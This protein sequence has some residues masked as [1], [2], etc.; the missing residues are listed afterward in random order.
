MKQRIGLAI[1]LLGTILIGV[2]LFRMKQQPKT[3]NNPAGS[4]M[5]GDVP[6]VP[7]ASAPKPQQS[8]ATANE[9][10]QE[11]LPP[12]KKLHMPSPANEAAVPP[13]LTA[14]QPQPEQAPQTVK[15][16]SQKSVVKQQPLVDA[17]EP[18]G[19][20]NNEA[21][22]IPVP[23]QTTTEA[24]ADNNQVQPSG[25][26]S[27]QEQL[28]AQYQ[29]VK[30]GANTSGYSVVAE[31]TLLAVQKGGILAVPYSDSTDFKTKYQ[32]GQIHTPSAFSHE[33][34]S[35]MRKFGKPQE[36]HLFAKG[37]KVYPTKID[38]NLNNDSVTL[39]IVACNP[40]VETGSQACNKAE[41]VFQFPKGALARTAAGAVEDVIG[42]VFAISNGDS[43]AD[44][45]GSP[46]G[47]QPDQALQR[48]DNPA[49]APA[50]I[51]MGMTPEEVEAIMGPPDKKVNIGAK[52]IYVYKDIRVL[53]MNG[54]VSDVQ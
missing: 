48:T 11:T 19:S 18:A 30:I 5:N 44:Q 12:E 25:A 35:L 42:Q 53:F 24:S 37:D 3:D 51:T 27:L 33:G 36:T 47:H 17:T 6:T 9:E 54:R 16:Q 32:N 41:V 2:A 39:G 29:M 23:A 50:T 43:N 14:A 45:E 26:V 10:R 15:E 13:D 1:L 8:A 21:A 49:S 38:V 20:A 31:G 40:S 4:A 7:V 34:N 28:A 22:P 46:A 52:Q